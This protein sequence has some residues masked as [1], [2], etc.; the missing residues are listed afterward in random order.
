MATFQRVN[1]LADAFPRGI[2]REIDLILCRNVFIYFERDA[3]SAVV[4]K[5]AATLKELEEEREAVKDLLPG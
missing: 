5:F 3:V 1:L 4:H 2:L